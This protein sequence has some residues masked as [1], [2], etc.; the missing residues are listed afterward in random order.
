LSAK[1]W[2]RL[3]YECELWRQGIDLVA[4]VDEA[5]C[6][7]LAG[8][9]TA[10]AVVFPRSWCESGLYSK[11]R[12]LNDSKQLTAEQREKYFA[13][14]TGHAEIRYAIAHADVEMIDRINIRQAAWRAMNMALDQLLLR[15]QH[16]LV[17]GLRIKWLTYP[18]TAL[19]QGDAKSYSIAAA[20]VLAKVTRDRLMREYDVVYPGYG[21]AQHKGYPTPTHFAA[22]K[23]LGPTP[24]HRRSFAPFRPVEL[25]LPLSDSPGAISSAAPLRDYPRA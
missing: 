20:S 21:F 12:G 3:S 17:D 8:P 1:Y 23:E 24:I 4:G 10:A 11:L 6:A 22:I 9:V 2:N 7:P 5:G 14:I 18:Q 19:V 16:V 13:I 15:P 25:E